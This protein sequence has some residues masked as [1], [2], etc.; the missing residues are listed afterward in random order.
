[1]GKEKVLSI[2]QGFLVSNGGNQGFGSAAKTTKYEPV[3]SDET[4]D[5]EWGWGDDDN[6]GSDN[7][8]KDDDDWGD[9]DWGDDIDSTKK[10]DIEMTKPKSMVLGSKTTSGGSGVN[11]RFHNS[12]P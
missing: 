6:N 12:I 8:D 1:M 10:N 3:A 2:V 7:D 9:D 11:N 4:N 5:E